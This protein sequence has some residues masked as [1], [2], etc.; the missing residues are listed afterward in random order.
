MFYRYFL[1]NKFVN[2]GGFLGFNSKR[3]NIHQT[4]SLK[5]MVLDL[6]FANFTTSN[7]GYITRNLDDPANDFPIL[8]A[9]GCDPKHV[10]IH[11]KIKE[12]NKGLH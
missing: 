11:N 3:I 2:V 10:N 7:S 8:Q 9:L 6:V 12:E 5:L 1:S 4:S